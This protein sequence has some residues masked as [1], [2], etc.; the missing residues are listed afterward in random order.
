[1]NTALN[2]GFF[3]EEAFKNFQ[4]TDICFLRYDFIALYLDIT[5]STGVCKDKLEIAVPTAAGSSPKA[6]CGLNNGMHSKH[7]FH[8]IFFKHC[9]RYRAV[10]F[11]TIFLPVHS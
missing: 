7:S 6:L 2:I 1:M 11:C 9:E 5:A 4:I 3:E 8:D 10:P